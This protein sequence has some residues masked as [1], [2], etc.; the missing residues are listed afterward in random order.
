MESTKKAT[1]P[2][3]IPSFRALLGLSNSPEDR[4]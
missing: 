1:I 2:T 4:D 3:I